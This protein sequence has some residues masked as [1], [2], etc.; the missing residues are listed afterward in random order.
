MRS[1]TETL[2][3]MLGLLDKTGSIL[4]SMHWTLVCFDKPLIA[5]SD[6]P[7]HVWPM[8]RSRSKPQV[9]RIDAG[10]LTAL[11]VRLPLTPRLALLMTW[12]PAEDP[13]EP[14][15]GLRHH[16][17]NINAFTVVEADRHWF[18]YPETRPPVG[19]ATYLP[20]SGDLHRGYDAQA[21]WR[22]PLRAEVSRLTQPKLG[23]ELQKDSKIEMVRWSGET[24]SRRG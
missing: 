16:P 10:L 13:P 6:Q 23:T 9:G 4:A 17:K 12:L 19:D 18:Y 5:T 14:V 11:E 20:I 3:R 15:K 2:T 8:E 21:A 1:S 24:P 7:V 22:S